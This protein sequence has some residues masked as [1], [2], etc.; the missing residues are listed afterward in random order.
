MFLG[1]GWILET[2]YRPF[3]DFNEMTIKRDLSIFISSYLPFLFL[4]YSHE[5]L[6]KLIKKMKH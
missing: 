1:Q 2:S 5:T 4:P 3:Y 6:F